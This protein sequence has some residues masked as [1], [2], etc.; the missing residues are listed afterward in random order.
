VALALLFAVLPV[1][2]AQ[3][4]QEDDA[5]QEAPTGVVEKDLL[6]DFNKAYRSRD[7]AE[8]AAAIIALGDLSRGLEDKGTSKNIAK[9]LGKGLDDDSLEVRAAAI[10]QLSWG[11]HVDTTV[12]AFK[13]MIDDQRKQLEK[14]MTRPDDESKEYVGRGVRVFHDACR[15]AAHYKDDRVVDSLAGQMQAL[16]PDTA[17]TK[18]SSRLVGNL[19]RSL[20][21]MGTAEAVEAAIRQTGVYTGTY[22]ERAAKELHQ[23]LAEFSSA[24]NVAPPDYTDTYYVAWDDWFEE[25]EKRFPKKLGKLK[26]PPPQ[27]DYDRNKMMGEVEDGGQAPR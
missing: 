8:R 5:E 6:A 4:P 22:Q 19:A 16:R 13:G 3:P 18:L 11:R 12:S 15:A 20:L 10:G 27:P 9:A 14:R 17:D 21:S 1:A 25:T 2:A 24:N 26:E 7:E 23:A